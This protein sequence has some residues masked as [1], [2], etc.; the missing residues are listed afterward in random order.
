ME[1][2]PS[3]TQEAELKN[4]VRDWMIIS[5]QPFQIYTKSQQAIAKLAVKK[6][7]QVMKAYKE[8]EAGTARQDDPWETM[9]RCIEA[10][11]Y[12]R[13]GKAIKI[14][15]DY[16]PRWTEENSFGDWQWRW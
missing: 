15:L 2:E 1:P 10:K 3:H 13:K 4:A 9:Q 11:S 8:K 6:R 16:I 5:Q 7:G 12:Q 14:T